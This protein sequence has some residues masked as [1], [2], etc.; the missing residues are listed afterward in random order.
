MKLRRALQHP[1]A[2]P[3][4]LAPHRPNPHRLAYALKRLLAAVL[5]PHP[6]H[7]RASDRTVSETSTSPGADSPLMREA[8]FT[9]P[10]YTFPP[11]FP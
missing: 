9:A 3:S 6:R 2:P 4:R 8:M 7:V 11:S 10:P 1:F 5:E